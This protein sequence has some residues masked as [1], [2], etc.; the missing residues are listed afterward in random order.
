MNSLRRVP[1]WSHLLAKTD[2]MIHIP[3]D[4]NNKSGFFLFF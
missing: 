2:E 4:E 3:A 1:P